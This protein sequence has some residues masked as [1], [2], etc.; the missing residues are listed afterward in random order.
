M[1]REWWQSALE[2]ALLVL[3]PAVVGYLSARATSYIIRYTLGLGDAPLL[4]MSGCIVGTIIGGSLFFVI[5]EKINEK[6]DKHGRL[7]VAHSRAW[8][9]RY[10]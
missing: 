10:L 4:V 2:N 9:R 6:R 8:G 5:A 7:R 3:A 1:T